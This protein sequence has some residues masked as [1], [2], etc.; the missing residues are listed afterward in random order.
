MEEVKDRKIL[1][2]YAFAIILVF[3]I[4]INLKG[5]V[6]PLIQ[7]DYNINYSQLGFI[8]SSYAFGSIL[9]TSIG[10]FLIQKI[11]LKRNFFVGFFFSSMALIMVS[12]INEY[13]L[14]S[15][16]MVIMGFG[17]G[18]LNVS[19]NTL[20]SR[21]FTKNKG[22]MM[23]VFH[24]FFGIGGFLAPIY[25]R[26]V[27]EF[28]FGW[29]ATYS[30][31]VIF[32]FLLFLF[33]LVCKFPDPKKSLDTKKTQLKTVL[34]DKR[35]IIFMLAFGLSV[36]LE[37]GLSSWLGVYLDD[38]QFRTKSEISFYLSVFFILFTLGRLIASLIVER[39]SYLKFVMGTT[40]ATVIS[41]FLGLIGPDSFA[42]FFSITG[43]FISMNFPTIQAAMFDIFEENLS[44]II[45]ATLTAGSLGNIILANWLTGMLNDLLGIRL[46]YGVMMIYGL[47][48]IG[49]V[50][51]AHRFYIRSSQFN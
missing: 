3:G 13:S 9:S 28:S 35:V 4:I 36:G 50:Y 33:T 17:M 16:A 43:F 24:L 37:I 21:I 29:E 14:L 23:N 2:G 46:G 49:L 42:I 39:F 45:G 51:Y 15:I 8:L 26:I 7:D 22:K 38:V 32:I 31:G 11:G 47:G 20:V 18:T 27:F 44:V 30:F 40:L 12:F 1:T 41:I 19:S 48:V 10:G 6:N 25:A 5:V 34:K